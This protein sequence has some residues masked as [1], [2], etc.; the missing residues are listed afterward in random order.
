MPYWDER[1]VELAK[2][3]PEIRL[4]KFHIDILTAHFV[5]IGRAHV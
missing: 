2:A 1:V 4:D 3:Y 5:Q